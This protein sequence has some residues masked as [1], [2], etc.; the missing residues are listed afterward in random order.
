MP[1]HLGAQIPA[2][3]ASNLRVYEST[4]S[5]DGGHPEKTLQKFSSL[6]SKMAPDT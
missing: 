5:H 1:L 6:V 2:L 3:Q 4:D